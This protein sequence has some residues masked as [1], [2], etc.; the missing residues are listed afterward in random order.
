MRKAV[1]GLLPLAIA[2][3]VLGV[4]M[5]GASHGQPGFDT[6]KPPYLL[7]AA[8]GVVID[9]ILTTG[10]IVPG[11]QT[12]PSIGGPPVPYQMTGIADGIGAYKSR[13]GDDDDDDDGGRGRGGDVVVVFNHE[14][15]RTFPGPVTGPAGVDARITRLEI[16]KRTRTVL[17]A[18]Y[19]F[20][21]HEGF[22]RFC[23]SFLT[24]IHGRPMY[25][26]GEEATDVPGTPA[27]R[28]G[29]SIALDPETGMWRATPHWGRLNHEN[30][31]P[32]RLSKW[33]ILSTDDDFRPGPSYLYAYIANDF[34]RAVR[35]VE[36]SLYVWKADNNAKNQNSTVVK[37]ESVPGRFIP[38]SQAPD[39][40]TSASLKAAATRENAFRFDR[41]EDLDPFPGKKGR[42][43]FVDTGKPPQTVRGRLYQFDIDPRDPTRATLKM[44]LNGDA[45]DND[46]IVNPDNIDASKKVL[47][48]QEDRESA[49][50]GEPSR[51]LVWNYNPNSQ[52]RTV[53]R[54][55][56]PETA[57]RFN[58]ESSGIF[59]ASHLLGKDWWLLDV[60]AHDQQA[61]QPGPTLVP[62]TVSGEDAQFL[63]I[64]IPN[65]TGDG[66]DD[67][68]DD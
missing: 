62:N 65:S 46:D 58:W 53:A 5:A 7:P 64:K 63:A 6:A 51:V 59:D 44:V 21:G 60:Q 2:V 17:D 33:V 66:D 39:N 67:D 1:L 45:P 35:G 56:R 3:A 38:L 4:S 68:D 47:V 42:T 16:D 20:T 61:L 49:F 40:A 31:V 34:N 43:Y 55:A 48:L 27:G 54:V 36:G 12:Q 52:P 32:I 11:S 9:P 15:G 24:M 26:T 13:G 57:S 41:L 10:D 18:E 37:G 50:R 25:F 30:V 19:L 29:T 28:D 8:P 23:S 22:E 14:T